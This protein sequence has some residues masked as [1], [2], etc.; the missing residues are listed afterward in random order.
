MALKKFVNDRCGVVVT[1]KLAK[2]APG[3]RFPSSVKREKKEK[4]RKRK[5]HEL[6]LFWKKFRSCSIAFNFR[7]GDLSEWLRRLI[8]NPLGSARVSSNLTVI[9]KGRRRRGEKRER[10]EKGKNKE[11]LDRNRLGHD[12]PLLAA[13]SC[14]IEIQEDKMLHRYQ[15]Y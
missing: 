9:V 11:R 10:E 2:L 14:R 12:N 1:Y 7:E 15:L 3:V 8:T 13:R 5:P 4:K 6:A